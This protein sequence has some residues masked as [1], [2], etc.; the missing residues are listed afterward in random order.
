MVISSLEYDKSLYEL[1][2]YVFHIFVF[3]P[4]WTLFRIKFSDLFAV[5]K[6]EYLNKK[7]H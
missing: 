2:V 3:C 4:K 5:I 1:M 7:G 6:E